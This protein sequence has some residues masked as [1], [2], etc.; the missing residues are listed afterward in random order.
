MPEPRTNAAMTTVD[1]LIGAAVRAGAIA[2]RRCATGGWHVRE[3]ARPALTYGQ[4]DLASA[5]LAAE[6]ICARSQAG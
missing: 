2:W 6:L 5:R 3:A 4:L 1:A